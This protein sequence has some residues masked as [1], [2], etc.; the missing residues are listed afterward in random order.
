MLTSSRDRVKITNKLQNNRPGEPPEGRLDITPTTADI[1]T[2][3]HLVG[4]AETQNRR[5]PHPRALVETQEGYLRPR[6]PPGGARGPSPTQ[7]SPLRAPLPGR[8]VPAKGD[9]KNQGGFQ[10]SGLPEA[11]TPPS[12]THAQPCSR[13]LTPGSG[14]G[15]VASEAPGKHRGR[16]KLCGFG[17]KAGGA[18]ARDPESGPPAVPPA[19]GRRLARA[20]PTSTRPYLD[21]I[22]PVG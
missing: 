16:L 11:Q 10:P 20:E 14:R 9:C 12:R 21:P 7:G 22:G 3:P 4:G 8:G 19:G 13:A 17:A 15:T 5:A 6:G 1:E 2:G 18:A